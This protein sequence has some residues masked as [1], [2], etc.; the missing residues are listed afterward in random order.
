[1]KKALTAFVVALV[2]SLIPL[3]SYADFQ[4]GAVGMYNGDLGTLGTS[5]LDVT[6]G[7]ETRFKFL[8]ICQ[9]GLTGLYYIPSAIGGST[10]ILALT[11][12]GLSF[13]IFFLRIGAGLGP[14]F[15]IPMA[16]PTVAPSSNANLKLSGDINIGPVSI[17][18]V[19]FY[20]VMSIWDLQNVTSMKPWLGLTAMIR[21]F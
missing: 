13:D 4:L 12:V 20:P 17:G 2:L 19:A 6:W 9:V 11:D 10:Y 15:L 21:L 14:D 3:P 7:I 5:P 1:M 8:S 18:V 16:G